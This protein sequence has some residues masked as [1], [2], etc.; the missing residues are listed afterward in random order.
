MTKFV[1]VDGDCHIDVEIT[2]QAATEKEAR[3]LA[4]SQLTDEQKDA[5]GYLECVDEIAA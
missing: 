5:C 4:W 1:F 2:V 3:K